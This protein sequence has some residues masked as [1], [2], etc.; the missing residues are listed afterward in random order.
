MLDETGVDGTIE[1]DNAL[2]DDY[3]KRHDEAERDDT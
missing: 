3:P 2:T 1:D